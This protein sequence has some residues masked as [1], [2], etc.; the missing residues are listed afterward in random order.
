MVQVEVP[1]T[2]PEGTARFHLQIF[3]VDEPSE[4]YTD[5]PTATLAVSASAPPEAPPRRRLPWWIPVAAVGVLAIGD[6]AAWLLLRGPTVVRFPDVTGKTHAAA[7][8]QL[9]MAKLAARKEMETPL[10][11]RTA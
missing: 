6:V 7:E 4:V 5:G 10:T 11:T 1:P 3:A 9:A 8:K 2:T